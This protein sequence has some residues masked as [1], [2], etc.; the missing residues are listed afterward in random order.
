MGPGLGSALCGPRLGSHCGP[1]AL[2][3]R[4]VRSR[5]GGSVEEAGVVLPLFGSRGCREGTAW[6]KHACRPCFSAAALKWR[7]AG[8]RARARRGLPVRPSREHACGEVTP[9]QP[10]GRS[11]EKFPSCLAQP[12]RLSLVVRLQR[13]SFFLGWRYMHDLSHLP[14]SHIHKCNH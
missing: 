13:Y 1:G 14:A 11:W 7:G 8:S 4:A 2:A 3:W 9:P 6:T 10:G 5:L 12:S